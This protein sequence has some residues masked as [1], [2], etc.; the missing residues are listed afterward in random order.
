MKCQRT[1]RPGNWPGWRL[2][3]ADMSAGWFSSLADS[4]KS[5]SDAL[6]TAREVA[7]KAQ[8][9]AQEKAQKLRRTIE[10]ELSSEYERTTT[11]DTA[12]SVVPPPPPPSAAAPVSALERVKEVGTQLFSPLE[13]AGGAPSGPSEPERVVMLPWEQPG[14]SEETRARMR[15]LSQERSI[16]LAPPAGGHASFRFDLSASLPLIM[17][18]LAVDKRLEEQRHLLVPRQVTEEQFF[19]HYFHHLHVLAH[20]GGG[21]AGSGGGSG[22]AG[23]ALERSGARSPSSSSPV[24]VSGAASEASDVAAVQASDADEL[25][26]GS[27]VSAHAVG[28]GA[29]AGGAAAATNLPPLATLLGSD[30]AAQDRCAAAARVGSSVSAEEQ[31]ECVS[32][33][34]LE[35]A[36]RSQRQAA[37]QRS[38]AAPSSTSAARA[39]AAPGVTAAKQ[40]T[41]S[42]E[43]ELRAELELS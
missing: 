24:L 5:A 3:F 1:K 10:D 14:L 38:A 4:V 23:A 21:G 7:Q 39:P 37:S 8:E 2:F 18:A 13:D 34:L 12:S 41:L 6:E 19:T 15:S 40:L 25:L 22:S 42:W 28:G 20:G 9:V 16:F 32:N 29:P 33:H 26:A 27:G 35:S 30:G 31:F 17:E 43:E 36:Q 11:T